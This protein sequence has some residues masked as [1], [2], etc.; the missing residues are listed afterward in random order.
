MKAISI[1]SGGLDSILAAILIKQSG[2]EVLPVFFSTPFFTP[3]KARESA[4]KNNLPLKVVDITEKYF[5]LLEK[6]KH[7]FG[8]NMNP[9]IDC[10][11]LMLKIA[12]NILDS[13]NADFLI[14]G[15]VLGQRPMSQTRGSLFKVENESTMKGLVLRPLS[16]KLLPKTIPELNGWVKEKSLLAISGRSRKPQIELAGRLNVRHYPAPAGGCLLTDPIFSRR[17]KDLMDN[18]PALK[19]NEIELLKLGRHFRITPDTKI[20]VGRNMEENE[21]I[22]GLAGEGG[23]TLNT[24]TVPGP[25]VYVSGE[26]SGD[27]DML[28]S[29]ITAAYS[30]VNKGEIDLAV[31]CNGRSELIRACYRDKSEFSSYMV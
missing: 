20:V 30:D 3:E 7:G 2:I 27:M 11:A 5:P 4:E 26:R 17:L 12:G 31:N 8:G 16:A 1:F 10:H 21:K 6:P 18:S 29:S 19:R 14:S 13:E 9:C 23:Y 15:E 24:I 22:L 28:A 25:V